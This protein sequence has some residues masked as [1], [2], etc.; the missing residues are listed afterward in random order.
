MK[1]R[2]DLGRESALGGVVCGI[3]EAGR[4][5]WAGPVMAAAVVLTPAAAAH[6]G[7][8][9]LD[10]SKRL[11]EARRTALA[12]TL[13]TLDGIFLGLGQASVA[14]IDRLNILAATHLAMARAYE[15]LCAAL[16][17]SL[18]APCAHALIDGN[19][20][21]ALPAPVQVHPLVGGDGKSLSIAAASIL[22][23]VTRDRLMVDLDAT[24]PGYGFARH[25]GYGTAV[26][27]A[28]LARLGPC[29]AHRRSFK[30]VR[31][32]LQMGDTPT[33]P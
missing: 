14:E 23:K 9:G 2:P 30:P 5:P 12:D 18:G 20:P 3:D 32:L 22:A 26:H 11:S 16:G 4:G 10:D 28:A 33:I 6:P 27:Q 24:H 17:N 29:P 15:T 1:A 7:L 13:T 25:K 31:D 19:R 8:A 21:P